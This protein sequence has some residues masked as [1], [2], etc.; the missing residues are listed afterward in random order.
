MAEP[1]IWERTENPGL[2]VPE[3]TL[4]GPDVLCRYWDADVTRS[5]DAAKIAAAQYMLEALEAIAAKPSP[6]AWGK[7]HCAIALAKGVR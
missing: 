2:T 3:M 7:V 5:K 1:W 4:R 6:D